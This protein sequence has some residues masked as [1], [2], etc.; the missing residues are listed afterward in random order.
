M[1]QL[2]KIVAFAAIFTATLFSSSVF[3]QAA[4]ATATA[5]VS[6]SAKST[7]TNA[8]DSVRSAKDAM[9]EAH[10][11]LAVEEKAIGAAQKGIADLVVTDRPAAQKALDERKAALI[12]AKKRLAQVADRCTAP[13]ATV[14]KKASV[15]MTHVSSSVTHENAALKARI[16]AL[17]Q[18]ASATATASASANAGA[19]S[20]SA[21]ASANATVNVV[22]AGG[23][24]V[25][26]AGKLMQELA[27][28]ANST[29][30]L[31]RA[32]LVKKFL[33]QCQGKGGS[34]AGDMAC[35]KKLTLD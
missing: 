8:R 19:S 29:C 30:A 7:A 35:G 27:P 1:K 17:E 32:I 10:A 34:E 4:A 23:C 24:G 6:A 2:K 13:V 3:A 5:T 26:F 12:I 16:I 18:K 11:S 22:E 15:A 25:T 28:R 31:D 20:A 9:D 14:P 33:A 21:S